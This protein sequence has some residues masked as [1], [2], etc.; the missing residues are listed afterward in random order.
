MHKV[1]YYVGNIH[2]IQISNNWL[3]LIN[4]WFL[5]D[6]GFPGIHSK[7]FLI[8]S[9]QEYRLGKVTLDYESTFKKKLMHIAQLYEIVWRKK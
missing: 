3:R 2:H 8:K 7:A 6:M 4:S 9:F 5:K 1:Q